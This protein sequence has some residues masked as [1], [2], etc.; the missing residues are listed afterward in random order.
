MIVFLV[1]VE[2][3]V[4][5]K[6]SVVN[7]ILGRRGQQSGE[8]DPGRGT[9]GVDERSREASQISVKNKENVLLPPVYRR[10]TERKVAESLTGEGFSRRDGKGRKCRSGG[11]GRGGGRLRKQCTGNGGRIG[12][13]RA[14][15]VKPQT[16]QGREGV[17]HPRGFSVRWTESFAADGNSLLRDSVGEVGSSEIAE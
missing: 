11:P 2:P 14:P 7:T 1:S 10:G 6:A 12:N 17:W 16:L 15:H 4:C 3:M 8:T 5:S 13:G 9:T